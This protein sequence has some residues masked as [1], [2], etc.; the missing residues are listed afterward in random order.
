MSTPHPTLR[1][2]VGYY[3]VSPRSDENAPSVPEQREWCN[4]A[5][6]REG[7]LIVKEFADEFVSGCDLDDLPGLM[8]LVAFCQEE[9]A[10]GRPVEVVICWDGDRFSRGSAIRTARVLD[11]LMSAGVSY[12]YSTEGWVDLEDEADVLIHNVKQGMSRS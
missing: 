6:P 8:A 11:D 4:M 2:T 9:H 12:L 5:A 10:A 1:R 7:L 3:R